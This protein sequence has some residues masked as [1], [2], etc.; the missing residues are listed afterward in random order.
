MVTD[1]GT[2]IDPA[3]G[4][5]GP[6]DSEIAPAHP[7]CCSAWLKR[8]RSDGSIG[9]GS[10]ERDGLPFIPV[11]PCTPEESEIINAVTGEP[12]LWLVRFEDGT[13]LHAW[14]DEISR[15]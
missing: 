2:Q 4:H 15:P 11:R 5:A 8:F 12:E 9:T 14:L 1:K 7:R 13:E 6:R 3:R 10:N